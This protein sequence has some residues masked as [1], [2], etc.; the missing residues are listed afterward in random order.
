MKINLIGVPIF[1]GCDKPGVDLGPDT[2]RKNGLLELFE[3][4][5]SITDLG[6]ISVNNISSDE[7]FVC[8]SKMK[9]IS[10]VKRINENLADKVY[11]SLNDNNFP[12]IVGGDH[13]LALGSVAGA[14]KYFK[15]DFAIIWIDAHGDINTDE[16]SPSGN[17]HGMPLAASMGIGNDHLTTLYSA[18]SKVN[19]KNVYILGARDLD[20]GELKLI[21]EKSLNVW[22]MNN[23]KEK[24][25][26]NCLDELISKL[27][28]SKVNNIH[29]SFDIDSLDPEFTPGTGTPV[30]DGLTLEAGKKIINTILS[31][32]K[33]KSLDFV[34]FN[35]TLDDT[36]TTL[37]TCFELLRE[38]NT[39]L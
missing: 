23:I 15:E 25:L 26:I 12:L 38:I 27:N 9:Y 13:S 1:Y 17:I 22:T 16:S 36:D 39:S 30:N 8:N 31:T 18:N 24:G 14:A 6:N 37:N 20:E 33:V 35:P 3:R 5:H 11:N 7:K 28:K 29:L 34:E 21:E 32:K 10:E 19:S 4:E 2:L